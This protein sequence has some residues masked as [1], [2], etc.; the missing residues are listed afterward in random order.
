MI[1]EI[2]LVDQTISRICRIP[3]E[4]MNQEDEAGLITLKERITSKVFGQDEAISQAVY[5]VQVSRLG[6]VEEHKPVASLLFVGPTGV[7]KTEAAKVLASELG[8]SFVRFDLCKSL[9]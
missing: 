3:A 7:G 5:A 4:T 1:A 8:I 6:L 9:L 2:D